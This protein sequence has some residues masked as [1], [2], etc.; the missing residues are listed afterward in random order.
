MAVTTSLIHETHHPIPFKEAERAAYQYAAEQQA[1]QAPVA[2][3]PIPHA[4][5]P[6]D[7]D[8]PQPAGER[9]TKRAAED[10]AGPGDQSQKRA[11]V[12]PKGPPL[13]RD[14]ENCTVFASELPP[15][16]QEE[17]LRGV[18]KDV[19]WFWVWAMGEREGD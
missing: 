2:D 9:G 18:F 7:V 13:K 3:A 4:D 12:E 15:N 8:A 14:R 11:K 17:D 16:V 19:S 10:D 6:M 5:A 1:A